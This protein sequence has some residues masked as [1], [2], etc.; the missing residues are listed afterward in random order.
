MGIRD[1][2]VDEARRDDHRVARLRPAR[3]RVRALDRVLQFGY[4]VIPNWHTRVTRI[5]YWS[6]FRRP[7]TSPKYGIALDAWWLD[8]KE[9][10][11]VEQRKG[12]VLKQ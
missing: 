1:P 8:P 11:V 7:E 10:Q 12:E 2:V 9:E 3:P 4:Y 6:K 5:A